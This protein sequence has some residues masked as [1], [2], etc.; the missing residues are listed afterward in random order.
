MIR[1]SFG[2]SAPV[3]DEIRGAAARHQGGIGRVAVAWARD[4]GTGWFLDAVSQLDQLHV[5]VGLNERGT[6]VEA[7]LRLLPATETLYAFFKH[8]RQTFHPKLY[9]FE[10]ADNGDWTASTVVVGSSNLTRGGLFT[11]FESSLT[12]V[13]ERADATGEEL[14]LLASVRT[15]WDFYVGAPYAHRIADEDSIRSLYEDGYLSSE[16]VVRRE[17]RRAGRREVARAGLPTAPPPPIGARPFAAIEVPFPVGPAE[18]APEPPLDDLDLPGEPPLPDRFYVRTLTEND[19][20]KLVGGGTGTFEP[21]IGETARDRY[22]TFWG[23][24]DDYS[25]ITRTLPREEWA[26]RGRL[27][28]AGAPAGVD[29]EV[30]L[31]YRHERPGHAAEHRL[32]LGPIGVVRAATPAAF[33]EDSLLVLERAA[34]SSGY[35]FIVR[36]LT[37]GDPGFADYAAYLTEVRPRHRYGYGP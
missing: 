16:A 4:E 26:A 13:V 7:L 37:T 28:S 3:I 22:P 25:L 34:N 20:R 6:T 18:P 19:V 17:R 8:P 1:V 15:E 5:A 21:D 11:N 24:P 10:N 29:V 9:W 31:W 14:A 33:D 32:R 23:W 27:F 12:A 36:L 2:P 30:M 35:D